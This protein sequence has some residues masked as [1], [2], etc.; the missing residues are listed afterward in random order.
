[1]RDEVTS[2]WHYAP[3][4]RLRDPSNSEMVAAD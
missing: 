2:G 4:Q 3:E 1:M